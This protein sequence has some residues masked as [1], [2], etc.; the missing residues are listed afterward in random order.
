M[1]ARFD[2]WFK[3][4]IEK[5][6][7]MPMPLFE[8]VVKEARARSSTRRVRDTK[9]APLRDLG[10]LAPVFSSASQKQQRKHPGLRA[11]RKSLLPR[12]RLLVVSPVVV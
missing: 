2:A 10:Q 4:E 9:P 6:R 8:A 12:R 11:V 1:S 3:R 5:F 7:A